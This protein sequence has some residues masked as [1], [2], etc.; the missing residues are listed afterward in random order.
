MIR[1]QTHG[2]GMS[3]FH[4]GKKEIQNATEQIRNRCGCCALVGVECNDDELL[5]AQ[6]QWIAWDW[7]WSRVSYWFVVDASGRR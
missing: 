2:H 7:M 3:L 4:E 5:V 6:A 1:L